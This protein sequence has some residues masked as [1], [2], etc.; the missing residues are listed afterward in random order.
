MNRATVDHDGLVAEFEGCW[1]EVLRAT[2]ETVRTLVAGIAQRDAAELADAFYAHM[3][4]LR[5]AEPFLAHDVVNHRLRASMRRW[6]VQTL[7][8]TGA[9][10]AVA[11]TVARQIELGVVHARVRMPLDLMARG[12]QFLLHALDARLATTPAVSAGRMD[13]YRYVGSLFSLCDELATVS[14]VREIRRAARI[15]EAYHLL[16]QRREALVERERQRALL[17][18]WTEATLFALGTSSRR[19]TV[20]ALAGSDFGRWMT[21]KAPLFFEDDPDLDHVRELMAHVDAAL[22]PQLRAMPA[23]AA[24][25]D[26]LLDALAGKL[27]LIRF[28]LADLFQRIERTE[29]SIDAVTR[30]PNR[31]YL[32]AVLAREI[33]EHT[34][35]A[36]RFC[37]LLVRPPHPAELGAKGS[38]ASRD[39]YLAQF[40]ATLLDGIRPGDHLFRYRDDLFMVVAVERSRAQGDS[41]ALELQAAVRGNELLTRANVSGFGVSV[42]IAEFDG[43]PDPDDLLR[44]AEAALA[45]A[46]DSGET[47]AVMHA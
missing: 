24:I 27:E 32:P 25:R 40:A 29:H 22:L 46:I 17:S 43:H 34:A 36:R 3:R 37:A 35:S 30:L 18:E 31:R 8:G 12:T 10:D 6:L 28:V 1:R 20:P 4:A 39:L 44:R 38:E 21:H 15:D 9:P 7:G 5:R 26:S 47:D 14:Y 45:E 23:D 19:G 42:G 13:A 11:A 16:A 41:L 33:D 2:P